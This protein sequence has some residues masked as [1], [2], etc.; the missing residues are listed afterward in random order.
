MHIEHTAPKP[1]EKKSIY[2]KIFFDKISNV[3][4]SEKLNPPLNLYREATQN[5]TAS[6]TIGKGQYYANSK[7]ALNAD[8]TLVTLD[9]K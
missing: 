7:G 1:E 5:P 9:N 3:I 2:E 8:S 4:E 6:I